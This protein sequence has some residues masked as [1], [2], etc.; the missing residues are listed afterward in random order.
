[1]LSKAQI[2]QA[3][4]VK[5]EKVAVPEWGGEVCLRSLKGWERDQFDEA[6]A[7]SKDATHARAKLVS[8]SLCDEAG[9]PLGFT[10]GEVLQL[11]EKNAAVLDRLFDVARRLCRF[12]GDQKADQEAIAKN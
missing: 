11:S 3:S 2:L 4:D 1:M 9:E 6:M 7:T 10:E 12:G 8:R 5:I